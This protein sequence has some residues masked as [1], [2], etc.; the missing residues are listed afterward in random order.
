MS[1]P[2]S[3]HTV[4]VLIKYKVIS[5]PAL[6]TP[7]FKAREARP[8]DSTARHAQPLMLGQPA[9]R[10]RAHQHTS[11]RQAR[12]GLLSVSPQILHRFRLT[13]GNLLL[14]GTS[15]PGRSASPSGM[16]AA[17]RLRHPAP[18]HSLQEG[19]RHRRHGGGQDHGLDEHTVRHRPHQ[20]HR[21]RVQ[22]LPYG[23]P[24]HAETYNALLPTDQLDDKQLLSKYSQLIDTGMTS[25]PQAN[26]R[27]HAD[28]VLDHRRDHRLHRDCLEQAGG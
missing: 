18:P 19:C 27:D 5:P 9:P 16:P 22:R 26:D 8:A 7:Q 15:Q 11:V 23:L 3:T 21:L 24:G 12:F 6:N 2:S 28:P 14:D 20:A 13:L 10:G 1:S 4:S 25:T 17:K